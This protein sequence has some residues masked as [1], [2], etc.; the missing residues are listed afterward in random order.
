MLSNHTMQILKGDIMFYGLIQDWYDASLLLIIASAS[1]V[2][3]AIL[4]VELKRGF[5]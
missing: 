3:L 5:R 2:A 1:G 4:Y